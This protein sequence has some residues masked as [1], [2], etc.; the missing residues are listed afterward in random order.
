MDSEHTQYLLNMTD[1]PVISNDSPNS[2]LNVNSSSNLTYP[3]GYLSGYTLHGVII[4][5]ILVTGLMIVIVVGNC[6]VIW[7]IAVDRNLKGEQNWF[8]ASLAVS[9]LLVGLVIMP[10]SLANEL[11]GYWLFGRVLC[12]LWLAIDVLLCTASILNLCLISLDRYWSITRVTYVKLRTQKKAAI[13]V[14]VVWLLSGIICFPP[15]VGWKRPPVYDQWDNLLCALT[16]DIG[17]VVY[18]T[19]GSFYIPLIILVVVY[20]KIYL[21][22]RARARKNLKKKKMVSLHTKKQKE[23][24]A[25]SENGQANNC[26]SAGPPLHRVDEQPRDED[27]PE[28]SSREDYH[29]DVPSPCYY[30]A[31]NPTDTTT[32]SAEYSSLQIASKPQATVI[33]TE[34][35]RRLLADDTDSACD[36]SAPSCKHTS[37]VQNCKT[38]DDTDS[39]SDST[40]AHCRP[41]TCND[42]TCSDNAQKTY[43]KPL[44][45]D[46]QQESD[47]QRDSDYVA[48]SVSTNNIALTVTDVER[49]SCTKPSTSHSPNN[50]NP[51]ERPKGLLL[52]PAG[53]NLRQ[54]RSKDKCKVQ[55]K[56]SAPHKDKHK[57]HHKDDPDKAK[58]RIARARER[59]ATIVLGVIMSTFILCWFPF[60]STYLI[61][62]C[63]G[64]QPNAIF[65]AVFFWAGYCNSALNP[66]IYTIFN[67]DFRHAFQRILFGTKRYK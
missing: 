49:N 6:L 65:F 66:I 51:V 32:I 27:D 35:K 34:E 16:D 60:F 44:L 54:L 58:K 22:A 19:L 26:L 64:V 62:V 20:F 57:K 10:L 28:S 2:S 25:V 55:A 5:S 38:A 23:S 67:R 7:A 36:S 9:D 41:A 56:E 4:A 14:A 1:L 29:S 63:R 12:E 48:Q 50:N 30:S 37:G 45:E 53:F 15:L 47:S 21:A 46:S 17:Y 31:V 43:M 33:P 11:M 13:M 59:R 61:S 24:E 18:S 42:S 40:A 3:V 39:A 8:I 52:S